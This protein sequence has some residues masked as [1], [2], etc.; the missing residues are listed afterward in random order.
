MNTLDHLQNMTSKLPDFPEPV[1]SY[2]GFKEHAMDC[3]HS[4]SWALLDNPHISAAR[5]FNSAG[6]VFPAHVHKQI[7]V[8]I[9]WFG[10]IMLTLH[11]KELV[12]KPGDYVGIPAGVV[13]SSQFLEDCWYLA[14]CVPN[15]PDWPTLD[16]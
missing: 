1:Q 10:S 16:D 14:V 13:H 7:E 12:L 8:L 6:T 9:P 4:F 2:P 11:G 5:W 3:G 15:N